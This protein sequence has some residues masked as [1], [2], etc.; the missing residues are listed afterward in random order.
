MFA[1]PLLNRAVLVAELVEKGKLRRQVFAPRQEGV[2]ADF[3]MYRL[4]T[5]RPQSGE[6]DDDAAEA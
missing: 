5:R 1:Q 2:P 3:V 6:H 4:R